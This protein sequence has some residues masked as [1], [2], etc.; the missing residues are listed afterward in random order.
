LRRDRG[1]DNHFRL[2]STGKRSKDWSNSQGKR[3]TSSGIFSC[4]RDRKY[5]PAF[6]MSVVTITYHKLT[7]PVSQSGVHNMRLLE[8][9]YRESLVRPNDFSDW[10]ANAESKKSW[11]NPEILFT[12][13]SS[14]FIEARLWLDAGQSV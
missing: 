5:L 3:S 4:S 6:W 13:D 1:P 7:E 11:S 8:V 14:G 2:C 10:P 12:T 9:I